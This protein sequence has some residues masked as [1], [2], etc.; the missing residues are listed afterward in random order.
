MCVFSLNICT[1]KIIRRRITVG[2]T[3]QVIIVF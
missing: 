1:G 3:S 2:I